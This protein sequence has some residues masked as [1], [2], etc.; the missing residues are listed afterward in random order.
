ME[1]S[2]TCSGGTGVRGCVDKRATLTVGPA[3][4][5]INMAAGIIA[6]RRIELLKTSGG[7]KGNRHSPPCEPLMRGN[8]F[9]RA[10]RTNAP[11]RR[12]R[13]HQQAPARRRQCRR[14][15]SSGKVVDEA[16]ARQPPHSWS[17]KRNRQ[18][19]R[20]EKAGITCVTPASETATSHGHGHVEADAFASL[21]PKPGKTLRARCPVICVFSRAASN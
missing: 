9:Q 13:L 19:V 10:E 8:S 2:S 21:Q 5:T 7:T 14:G 11:A 3:H 15:T 1:N 16:W 18:P 6:T 4:A 17:L 12:G 20:K